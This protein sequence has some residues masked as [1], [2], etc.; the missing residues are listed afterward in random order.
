MRDQLESRGA[1][2]IKTFSNTDSAETLWQIRA[3]GLEALNR[4]DHAVTTADMSIPR[5]KAVALMTRLEEI[6]RRY[7]LPI[8]NTGH[9]GSG[10]FQPV[11][12]SDPP[13]RSRTNATRQ[14]LADM[15]DTVLSLGGYVSM[16]YPCLGI[17]RAK[18]NRPAP[19]GLDKV[20]K[21]LKAV[22]DPYGTLKPGH[23]F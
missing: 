18:F 1:R 8:T 4:G 11:I 22:F 5:D 20:F 14:A 21:S 9:S 16:T 23:S 15:S 3:A 7:D 12:V 13:K 6:S 2:S 10:V 19:A 17:E